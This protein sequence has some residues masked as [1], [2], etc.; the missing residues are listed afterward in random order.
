MA[1]AAPLAAWYFPFAILSDY[2]FEVIAIGV[3]F[4]IMGINWGTS[5]RRGRRQARTYSGSIV[6]LPTIILRVGLGLTL[7]T[8]ALHNKLL[9]PDLALTFFDEHPMNFM[10]LLGFP[11]FTN[12]HFAFAVGVAELAMGMLLIWGIATRFVTGILATF[13][14]STLVMFGP[15]ELIGHLPLFGIAAVLIIR[16]GGS[17][18]LALTEA[19]GQLRRTIRPLSRESAPLG[20]RKSIV[21]RAPVAKVFSYLATN[22]DFHLFELQ[23]TEVGTRI[24]VR[25][26]RRLVAGVSERPATVL[27]KLMAWPLMKVVAAI[28]A[29]IL[30]MYL[31][32]IRA[33]VEAIP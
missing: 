9:N 12:L 28:D 29:W 33:R 27:F 31:R 6:H 24:W 3:T 5:S 10:P 8:L 20:V 26:Q 4:M 23:S 30:S 2:L 16:G 7:A 22:R 1:L 32:R 21:V 15:S 25:G 17:T 13:L 14:I 18:R 19:D 11:Q